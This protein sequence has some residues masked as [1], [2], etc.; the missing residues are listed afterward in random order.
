MICK[1]CKQEIPLHS[2]YCPQC[3]AKLQQAKPMKRPNGFGT[4]YKL[5]GHR[6][7]PWKARKDGVAVGY[8]A[9]RAEALEALERLS[10]KQVTTRYNYTF[11]Q[12]VDEWKKEHYKTIGPKGIEGYEVAIKFFSPLYDKTFRNLRTSDFQA[13]ID[14]NEGKSNSTLSKYK[15]LVTQMS[16]WAIKEEIITTNFAS[17]VQVPE[18]KTKEKEIFTDAEI[19]RIDADDSETARIVSM[20]IATGMR[21]NELFSLPLED[22]H[23]KYVIGGSKTDA[24]KNRVIPIRPEGRRHFEYFAAKSA[25]RRKLLDSYDGNKSTDNFR[26]RDYN[27][28]LDRLG[29]S[30]AKTPHATRHTYTTRAVKEGMQP[31]LLQKILGHADYSTTANIYTHLGIEDLVNA[32]EKNTK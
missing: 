30:T 22:Y 6:R 11:I 27:T 5:S 24:G 19:A 25:G 15:Q 14:A 21:I 31:E 16:T 12:V 17:F 29:I 1:K 20:L 8:Y 13:I 7:R 23:G 26:K 32:V 4:V 2:V 18:T 10:G 3:G 28:L 9:T